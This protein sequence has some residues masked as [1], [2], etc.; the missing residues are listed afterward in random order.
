MTP[1]GSRHR[2]AA[3]AFVAALLIAL[4]FPADAAAHAELDT[5]SPADGAVLDAPPDEI[6]FTYTEELDPARSA[7]TL[8]DAAGTQLAAGG[9]DPSNGLAMRIDPPDIE[10]GSY[11][12]RSAAFSA[13]DDHLER[14]VVTFTITAPTPSPTAEPTPSPTAEPSASAEATPSP[15][16]T[17][18]PS[19]SPSGGGGASASGTDVL[20]PVLALLVIAV[21][22]AA[23][24]L[25]N[26]SRRA[27]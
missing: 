25:R 18:A 15:A 9:V 12:V 3:P 20:I 5:A 1:L 24:L 17:P 2:F 16:A 14:E 7:L 13:H 11:E 6:V 8:H 22:F 23:W 19:P 26:R 10:P 21:A 4:A 27:P